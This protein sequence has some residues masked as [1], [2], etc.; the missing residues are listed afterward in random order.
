MSLI[1]AEENEAYGLD[2]TNA[3]WATDEI[4]AT[5]HNAGLHILSDAD[6]IIETDSG[7]IIIEFKNALISGA[8]NP[9]AFNPMEDKK[10]SSVT[11]KYYDT[12]HYL[13]LVQK[14]GPKRYVYI[15]EAEH[16]D[17]VLRS[18]LRERLKKELPFKLQNDLNTGFKLIEDVEVLSIAE[19]N[20]HPEYKDYPFVNLSENQSFSIHF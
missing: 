15:V 13:T 9:G 18:R 4:H 5:Y 10:I 19:W 17:V 20:S 7:L 14:N 1:L 12:L 3:I 2:C 16:S 8:A 11:R 6:F